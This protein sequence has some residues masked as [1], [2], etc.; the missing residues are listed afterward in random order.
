M[1]NYLFLLFAS[2]SIMGFSQE[3][4]PTNGVRDKNHNSHAFINATVYVDAEKIINDGYLFIK[5]GRT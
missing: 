1:K 5:E 4:F 2:F 3:N